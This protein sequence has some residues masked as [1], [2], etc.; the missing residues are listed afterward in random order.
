VYIIEGV[1]I[2]V[3]QAV[4]SENSSESKE[5]STNEIPHL[6][7]RDKGNTSTRVCVLRDQ[8]FCSVKMLRGL[9]RAAAAAAAA[10]GEVVG[11]KLLQTGPRQDEAVDY[12]TLAYKFQGTQSCR[13]HLA[14]P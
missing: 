4:V 8:I 10:G 11:V 3:F 9:V 5:A 7:G 6:P 14:A 2:E 1:N 12:S 13:F